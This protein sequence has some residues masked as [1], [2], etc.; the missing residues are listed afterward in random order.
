MEDTPVSS[1]KRILLGKYLRGELRHAPSGE[2]PIPRRPDG[3]RVPLTFSQEQVW[4]HAQ[5]AQNS[6]IYNDSFA[7]CHRGPL[8]VASL[9][10][11]IA[12]IVRRH[13]TLRTTFD[14]VNGEPVQVI[15]EA[16]DI[17]LPV[18][19]LRGL[20]ED[21]RQAEAVRL[22]NENARRPFDL[23]HG[24]LMRAKMIRLGEEEYRL[25]LTLHHLIYDGMSMYRVFLP[26]LTTLYE[27]F[28]TG[29]PLPLS[30]PPIQYGDYA[31][32]QRQ[33]RQQEAWA[34][35]LGYWR[36]QLAGDLPLLDLPTD[37][38][39]PLIQ[40]FRGVTE[41]FKLPQP[42]VEELTL[43]SRR[44]R[45]TLYVTLLA[46]FKALLYRY[47]GQEDIVIGGITAGRKRPE[48]AAL[49]GFFLNTVVLRTD[50][51]G[52]PSF[53][54]LL[55]RV[56]DVSNRA[57][58][59]DEV[60]FE[61]LVKELHPK[62][63][64]SRNPIFQV[65]F[66]L[67]PPLVTLHEGWSMS[68]GD[69]TNASSMFDLYVDLDQRQD[70]IHGL[71]TYN[72]DLFSSATTIVRNWLTLM[73]GAANDP[74]LR[75]S[76][77]PLLTEAERRQFVEWNET[78]SEYPRDR[79]IHDLFAFRCEHSAIEVAVFSGDHRLTYRELHERSNRLA[80][81]LQ[82][83]GVGPGVPVGICMERSTDMVVGLFAI[84][85]AGGAYVPLDPSYPSERLEFMLADCQAKVLLTQPDLIHAVPDRIRKIDLNADWEKIA[86]ESAE[87]PLSHVQA[88]DTAYIMYT[89]GSTGRPKG[90][91]G[92][93]RA[94][95]N[96]LS[97]MW[98][99]YPFQ[100]E[101][102]CCQKTSLSFVDSVWEIFGPLLAGVPVVIFSEDTVKHVDTLIEALAANCVTRIVLVPS[103]LRAILSS[104]K[105]LAE[106]LNK[107]KLWIS[108]GEVLPRDLAE[109]FL[110][111]MPGHTLL[112]LYGST[113]VA[114]DATFYEVRSTDELA[115]V[116]IGRPI[117]NTQAYVLDARQQIAPVNV[118]G[119][120]YIGGDA[121]ARGYLNRPEMT[122]ERFIPDPFSNRPEARLYRTGDLG[123]YLI[124]GNIEFLGRRDFQVKIR[125][126][127]VELSEVEAV[128]GHHPAV[129]QCVTAISEDTSDD[130]R[131]VAYFE[132]RSGQ[133]LTINELRRYLREQLPE[134]M[135]PS[136]FVAIEKLPLTPNGKIDRKALP[137]SGARHLRSQ[138]SFLAPRDELE[139][140][141]AHLW[142]KVLKVPCVGVHDNFFELGGHSLLALR[143]TVEI[144]KVFKRRLPLATFLQAPTIAALAAILRR[145]NWTP[146]WSSLVPIRAGGSKPPLFLMHAHGGNVLEYHPLVNQLEADQPVYALQARGLDGCINDG[147]SIEEMA[148]TYLAEIRSL[149]PEGPYFLGGFCFGGLLALQAAQ[150]LSKAGEEVALLILIQTMNPAFARFKPGTSIFRQWWYRAAKRLDL[151]RENLSYRGVDYLS[152]RCRD[153]VHILGT[154]TM[155]AVDDAITKGHKR[156]TKLSMRYILELLRIEH[157]KAYAR[158]LPHP[159][160][161]DVLLL[162]ARKQLSGLMIDSSSGW[163]QLVQGNLDICEVPGHQQNM[164]AEP[165]VLY[166]AQVLTARLQAVQKIRGNVSLAE[167]LA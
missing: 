135:I 17:K 133:Q 13:E 25:Y 43:L 79:C 18:E 119:E 73:E 47:T 95:V 144:E 71:V 28:C 67:E 3:V 55:G 165:N 49:I 83:V 48:T 31:F 134:Y 103:L 138:E 32:W 111:F 96:R 26:E 146:S 70:G 162:R 56:R 15:H 22:A 7:I 124:N 9:E 152:E 33:S 35:Q 94:T 108:S 147:Q 4:L 112:N 2:H 76:E 63:D 118:Q 117:A 148:T 113:E 97:W 100:R 104:A 23:V 24:P 137:Y 89:S 37:Y 46:S 84:L 130:K 161:G 127:R 69:V 167:N 40:T 141:L 14:T 42:L 44:E 74:S 140:V 54:E 21:R 115:S 99:Q 136:A 153:A 75:V 57:L 8:D 126:C 129:R 29:K 51:S 1:T 163:K 90:V 81:Y 123:R 160:N 72:P 154:R 125:G 53:V 166:L 150:Q 149:Q 158:Y 105:G 61:S 16:P 62:R 20:P 6:P 68:Q 77:L 121:V 139:Q 145:E 157:A 106:K 143:I 132:P 34:D 82:K 38:P 155:I 98:R 19:D 58:A 156:R 116:P 36:K 12:E 39:R 102:I 164:L 87:T 52:D 120:I 66:T 159:Y 85:K 45:V 91:I 122:A 11:S 86:N 131:L 142:S 41:T 27:V 60:P 5:L 92:T 88:E 114:A 64:P 59:N 151:E 80:Q 50:L 93:H 101:E 110:E 128:L 30:E 65:M 78:C 109:S 10:R 107:L